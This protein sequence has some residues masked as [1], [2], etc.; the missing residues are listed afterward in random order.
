MCVPVSG[1]SHAELLTES[2]ASHDS[3]GACRR[4]EEVIKQRQRQQLSHGR[5]PWPEAHASV[6][7]HHIVFLW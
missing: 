1:R 5:G 2:L 6:D 4:S 3:P 7:R